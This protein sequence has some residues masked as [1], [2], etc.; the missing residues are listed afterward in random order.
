MPKRTP[1]IRGFW[2]KER[3]FNQKENIMNI[4]SLSKDFKRKTG[5]VE[6]EKPW[7]KEVYFRELSAIEVKRIEKKTQ[8]SINGIDL[9]ISLIMSAV[10]NKDGTQVFLDHKKDCNTLLTLPAKQILKL[11]KAINDLT[12]DGLIEDP[13]D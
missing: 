1:L 12:E 5:S 11:G 4:E 6:M 2:V 10:I 3:Q 7:D 13:K 8:Q 9:M